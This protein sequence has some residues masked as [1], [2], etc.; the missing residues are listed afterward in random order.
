MLNP[1]VVL[2][3][4]YNVLYLTTC[5]IPPSAGLCVLTIDHT[6]IGVFDMVQLLKVNVGKLITD[7][8]L[9]SLL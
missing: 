7:K 6:I 2:K 5:F 9:R 1:G 3:C 4:Q 8:F